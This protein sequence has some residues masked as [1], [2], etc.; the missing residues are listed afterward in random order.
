MN[1]AL[2]EMTEVKL[3]ISFQTVNQNR[4]SATIWDLAVKTAEKVDINPNS[5]AHKSMKYKAAPAALIAYVEKKEH[6]KSIRRL[7]YD[8]YGVIKDENNWPTLPDGSKMMFTP[9]LRGQL[10]DELKED[11]IENMVLHVDLKVDETLLN[12]DVKNIHTKQV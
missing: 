6:V 9:I 1:E 3:E 7:L 12:V 5:K 4:V 11:L 8:N 2:A 10:N